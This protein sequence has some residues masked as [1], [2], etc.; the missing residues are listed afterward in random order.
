M[1]MP[2]SCMVKPLMGRVAADWPWVASAVV[3]S[4]SSTVSGFSESITESKRE[5]SRPPL[6]GGCEK[7]G[8][9]MRAPRDGE[10]S[11]E[12]ALDGGGQG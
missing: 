11:E 6:G 2:G 5:P 3:S 8:Q 10:P 12:G 1:E 9:R 7:T 4:P